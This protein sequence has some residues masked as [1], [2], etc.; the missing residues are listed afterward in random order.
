M[1]KLSYPN[2]STWVQLPFWLTDHQQY[3]QGALI[4]NEQVVNWTACTANV[5]DEKCW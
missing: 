2:A 1:V 5:P 4:L 3:V